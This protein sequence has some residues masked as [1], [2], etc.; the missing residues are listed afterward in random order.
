MSPHLACD[1]DTVLAAV[2]GLEAAVER[3]AGVSFDGLTHPEV[4]RVLSTL[5]AVTRRQPVVEQRLIGKLVRDGSAKELGAKSV[6]EVLT[7]AL[8]ISPT[9]ANRRLKDVAEFG[10]RTSLTGELLPPALPHVAAG[11]AAGRI[12]GEHIAIIRG[13]FKHLPVWVDLP[14]REKA[15]AQ[16]AEVA[17]EFGPEELRKAAALIS[18][19][20]N[21]DGEFSD[22]DRARKRDFTI[23]RQGPDGMSTVTGQITPELR[24]TL[25]AVFSKWAAPGMCTPDDE[26][27]CIKGKPSK[28]QVKGDR[29]TPGQRQHDALTAMGR[30]TL[31]SGELGSHHGL[32]VTIVVSATLEELESGVGMAIT[33]GGTRMPMTDMV[34]LASHA[35]HYLVVFDEMGRVLDLGRSKR[36]ASADQRI[37]L[38]AKDRGCTFPGCTVPGFLTEV[39]HAE[40]DWADDGVTNINDLTLACGPHNRLVKPGGWR[41]RKRRDGRTEWIP[42]PHLDTGQGR[43]NKQHHPEELLRV[44]DETRDQRDDFE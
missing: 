26:T 40:C 22:A 36:I 35:F 4:V 25:Q 31:S 34:R 1:R 44:D 24:A 23:G 30:N 17:G 10:E 43:I 6:T 29:R 19:L 9:E 28:E 21:P 27:P 39:H 13:F 7:T 41:T 42:P 3:L 8:R 14:T 12:G 11:Q 18:A 16:L 37:V 32:P 20:V 38:H 15:E 33:S 5:E 2:A